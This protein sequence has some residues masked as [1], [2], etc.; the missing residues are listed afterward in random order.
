MGNKASSQRKD[1]DGGEIRGRSRSFTGITSK[2]RKR[3]K[4]PPRER[5]SSFTDTRPKRGSFKLSSHNGGVPIPNGYTPPGGNQ[6]SSPTKSITI[7]S[8]GRACEEENDSTRLLSTSCPTRSRHFPPLLDSSMPVEAKQKDTLG[9]DTIRRSL[10]RKDSES[11]RLCAK[12]MRQISRD[13]YG[14]KLA[15]IS[16]RR[17]LAVQNRDLSMSQASLG[18]LSC[19]SQSLH[20]LGNIGL[21]DEEE[22]ISPVYGKIVLRQNRPKHLHMNR[23]SGDFDLRVRAGSLSTSEMN[24]KSSTLRNSS[25]ME[26]QHRISQPVTSSSDSKVKVN[27]Q[28]SPEEVVQARRMLVYRALK[29][30][31]EELGH[32]SPDRKSIPILADRR[33]NKSASSLHRS[34]SPNSSLNS[35]HSSSHGNSALSPSNRSVLPGN[36]SHHSSDSNS[37]LY[38]CNRPASPSNRLSET[39]ALTE[40]IVNNSDLKNDSNCSR[41]MENVAEKN[42]VHVTPPKLAQNKRALPN[43]DE[44]KILSSNAPSNRELWGSYESLTMRSRKNEDL[45]EEAGLRERSQSV[46]LNSRHDYTNV[47]ISPLEVEECGFRSRS[48]SWSVARRGGQVPVLGLG[49]SQAPQVNRL[50]SYSVTSLSDVGLPYQHRYIETKREDYLGKFLK[51]KKVKMNFQKLIFY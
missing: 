34:P 26:Q 50:W 28:R 24:R 12:Q 33:S 41:S 10:T 17:G 8:G 30:D 42:L 39:N 27:A 31:G 29:T 44:Y 3:S 13:L 47:H 9:R 46:S 49:Q 32:N 38:P 51:F 18:H 2:F 11:P 6:N 15:D 37:A 45:S 36:R 23:Y 14:E 1:I 22:K 20:S 25:P 5:S 48:S 7:R 4:S 21:E 40:L 35:H 16:K 19:K 43:I